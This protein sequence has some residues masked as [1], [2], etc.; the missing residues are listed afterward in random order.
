[1]G[2][3]PRKA[4]RTALSWQ[5]SHDREIAFPGYYAVELAEPK[6]VAE[7]TA[8]QRVGVHRYT[9]SAGQT[10]HIQIHATSV[11]GKGRS[12]EGELRVLPGT[13]EVEG[14]VRTFGTFSGRH[15]GGKVYF[16]AR[17]SSP[18]KDYA[19]WNAE[20]SSPQRSAVSGDDLGVDLTFDKSDS[21]TV[22]ELK[23]AISYVSVK[24]ARANLDAEAGSDGFDQLLAKAKQQ[25]E[26]DLSRIRIDGGTVEQQTIFYTALYHS[27]GMPTVFN[28]VNGEYLGFDGAIH[29]AAGF[30]YYTDMS[31]WDTFRT[32]HPL[33]TMILPGRQRDMVVSLVEMAKQGGYLPRWPS[34]SGYTNSMFGTPADIM[35]TDTYLKG[36]RDFDVETAY[37]AMKK[38]ALGPTPPGAP[39]SGRKEIAEYLKF[40]YCPA[41][42]MKQAVSRNLEYCYADHAIARLGRG[43]GTSRGCRAV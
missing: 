20:T 29:Q 10:P 33:F 8:T 16:V 6:V 1:M 19:T 22:V 28:D 11:L 18:F 12:T 23:L 4:P 15:G 40:Q 32:T 7:M 24:N 5:F 2:P 17:S 43:P 38:T 21:S 42:L 39:F 31:L 37:Q 13:S 35:I 27:L 30:T 9:F 25:W 26:T 41:D 14:S 3:L 34:G 36:I